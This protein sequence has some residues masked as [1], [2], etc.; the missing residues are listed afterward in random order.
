MGRIVLV[1]SALLLACGHSSRQASSAGVDSTAKRD[2][3][4]SVTIVISGPFPITPPPLDSTLLHGTPADGAILRELD[5]ATEPRVVDT[6]YI[7]SGEMGTPIDSSILRFFYIF[8]PDLYYSHDE[9]T[10]LYGVA[11]F[12][13]DAHHVGYLLRRPGMYS[14]TA[15]D[16]LTYDESSQRFAPP[17]PV[18]DHWGDAGA[19]ADWEAWLVDADGDS[20]LDLFRHLDFGHLNPGTDSIEIKGDSLLF[21]RWIGTGYS[22]PESVTDSATRSALF[23]I[24][25]EVQRCPR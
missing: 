4:D 25:C 5:A 11:R 21:Y 15:I 9:Y 1:V 24:N 16:L 10:S 19:W 2:S 12:R 3:S 23:D 20:A 8:Y 18:A 22:A 13:I 7:R 14:S 17:V 6:L